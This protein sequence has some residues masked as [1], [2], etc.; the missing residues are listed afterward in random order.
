VGCQ[1]S[2]WPVSCS[3]DQGQ[4]WGIMII[5]V[6]APALPHLRA[7]Q[8]LAGPARPVIGIQGRRAA[9][10][11]ARGRGAA[12]DPSAAPAGLGRPGGPRRADPALAPEAADAPAGHPGHH[13]ALAPPPRRPQVDLPAPGGTAAGQRRYRRA[14]R[15]ARHREAQLGIPADPRRTAQARP[16]GQRI[17]HPPGPQGAEDPSGTATAP[18][19]P[20]GSSCIFR[21]PRCSPPTSS[22]WT[23]R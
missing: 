23:A 14:D 7:A 19:R 2:A 4:P 17:H 3:D 13:P 1:K 5:R 10:A 8:R 15:A 18:T 22:T 11:A 20:G 9:R 21:Q 16:P 6:L 12:P